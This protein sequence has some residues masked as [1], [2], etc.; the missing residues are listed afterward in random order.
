MPIEG[1]VYHHNTNPR[2]G[3]DQVEVELQTPGGGVLGQTATKNDGSFEFPIAIAGTYHVKAWSSQHTFVG[4]N[5][6]AIKIKND[7]DT[8]SGVDF[9]VEIDDDAEQPA[10]DGDFIKLVLSTCINN[11]PVWVQKWGLSKARQHLRHVMVTQLHKKSDPPLPVAIENPPRV[12]ASDSCGCGGEDQGEADGGP[13]IRTTCA[14]CRT[15]YYNCKP[16]G[17]PSCVQAYQ[18]C[19]NQPCT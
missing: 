19:I 3:I 12:V 9:K 14:Q 4:S 15:N 10:M 18:N 13:V 2:E 5:T 11:F 7:G 17:S 1:H 6:I 8:L 16:F